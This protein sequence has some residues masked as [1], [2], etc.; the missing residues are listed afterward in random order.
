M[1]R[2]AAGTRAR[3]LE[4]LP[5]ARG[6]TAAVVALAAVALAMSASDAGARSPRPPSPEFVPGQVLV[7]F[8]ERAPGAVRAATRRDVDASVEQRLPLS[9]LELL[10]LD[11]GA[12]VKQVA[13]GLERRPDVKYAEPNFY[14]QP[15]AGPNDPRFGELWGLENTGQA[16]RGRGGA[17][18]ADIDALG[19]WRTTRGD[20]V[21]KVA[22]TDSGIAYD[23]P[24]L[25]DNVW[26]NAAEAGGT[27]NVDDD[28]NG[29]VDDVH[30]YDFANEDGDPYDPVGH[31]THVAGTIG[32]VGGNGVGITG[33]SQRVSLMGLKAGD[34]TGPTAATTAAAFA[35]AADNHAK[36]VNASFG[37]PKRSRAVEQAI[38]DSPDVLFVTAAGND[39]INA[40]RYPSYPCNFTAANVL[41]VAASTMKDRLAG[42]STYGRRSVDLAAPGERIVSTYPEFRTVFKSAFESGLAASG[43]STG[44]IRSTWGLTTEYSF[45]GG[46]ALT[47]SPRESYRKN[48]D[49][50]AQGPPVDKPSA[51]AGGCRMDWEMLVDSEEDHDFLSVEESPDGSTWTRLKR[52][53]GFVPPD[54]ISSEELPG[55]GG[56]APG[57]VRFR[58][59]SDG[60]RRTGDGVWL[61]D[62]KVS[63]ATTANYDS[64][65]YTDLE[66]TS[67]ATPHVTGAAA[68]LWAKRPGAS[69]S[70]VRRGLLRGVDRKRALRDKLA[71]GGRLNARNALSELDG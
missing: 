9:G 24:D 31:G 13:A 21:V 5:F 17:A 19:A 54:S 69:V 30:G 3:T 18:D 38:K 70:R 46:H 29:Y 63:C 67:M 34:A 35:Y 64:R 48:T 65:S 45:G 55:L 60:N 12:D 7:R 16:V 40:D 36:V 14:F 56:G 52:F 41:C 71:S 49:S 26:T 47:D 32:G 42:F 6:R 33:V 15:L 4:R 57:H 68:L 44:G 39:G 1:R 25:T 37:A 43:W 20:R 22:V 66:G 50:W 62:V 58:L 10:E 61:D 8:S 2:N 11:R 27:P 23:H 59:T 53:S 51:A 28:Q